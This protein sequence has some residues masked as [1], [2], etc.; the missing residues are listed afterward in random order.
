MKRP[1]IRISA[2]VVDTKYGQLRQLAEQHERG[3]GE[4][5]R[6]ALDRYLDAEQ[7]APTRTRGIYLR[8]ESPPR[9][10]Q[11]RPKHK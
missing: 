4:L 5:L 1:M 9:R 8:P 11:R 10:P 2:F 3:V 7:V 6:E